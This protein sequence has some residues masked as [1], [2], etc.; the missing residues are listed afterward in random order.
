MCIIKLII[1]MLLCIMRVM[2]LAAYKVNLRMRSISSPRGRSWAVGL[3]SKFLGG[4]A[5][6]TNYNQRQKNK[7][8]KGRF[9]R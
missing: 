8:K 3:L 7:R 2:S 4:V 1:I 5:V 6:I 9:K